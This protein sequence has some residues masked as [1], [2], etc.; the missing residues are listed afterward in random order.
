MSVPVPRK[1]LSLND[2]IDVLNEPLIKAH[3]DID[4]AW[5]YVHQF[6]DQLEFILGELDKCLDRDYFLENYYCIRDENGRI[7]TLYPYWDHQW[8]LAEAIDEEYATK[9]K[10]LIIV[11]KPRQCGATEWT[12]AANFH[13]TIFT[14]NAFTLSVAQDDETKDQIFKKMNNAY[15]LLPWWMRPKVMF[16]KE[17][18]YLEFQEPDEERRITNP[19]LGSAML[20]QHAQKM[21]GV[22]IGKTIRNF[23]G[24]E[25]SR[26][27]DASVF[28]SDIR[29]S[30]NAD[31]QFGIL[32]STALGRSGFYYNHWKGAV[33]GKNKWRPL[34][35]PVYKVRKYAR[36]GE[37]ILK[38]Q[39][40]FQLDAKEQQFTERVKKEEKFDIPQ[41]FWAWRRSEIE[42]VVSSTGAPWDHFESYPIT[43]DEAFQSSGICAFDRLSLQYQ[44]LKGVCKP[45]WVGEIS[46]VNIE[47]GT[48]DTSMIRAVGD[49]ETLMPRKSENNQ[50]KTD[51]LYIW[52]MPDDTAFYQISSDTALGVPDGDYSV[53]QVIRL[54]EGAEPDTQVAEWWGHC[55]PTEFAKINAALGLWYHGINSAAEIATEY[56]GPGISCGDKLKD[57]DYPNLYRMV[58][59]DRVTNMYTNW[60]HWVTNQKT[61]DLI[62]ATTNEALLAHTCIIRSEE[63][64]DEMYDFGSDGGL[65]F[66]GQG[67]FDDGVMSWQIGLYCLREATR[68]MKQNA[69][70]KDDRST[71]DSK[72]HVFGVYDNLG[73]QR[74]QYTEKLI[75]EQMIQGKTNWTVKPIMICKAN[76]AF[77]P[78]FHGTGAQNELHRKYGMRSVDILPDVVSAYSAAIETGRGSLDD[79]D[80]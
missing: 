70:P 23:H 80:W 22:A 54:G 41:S 75:A 5:E 62:I 10:C 67:N 19:G 33:A 36:Q 2:A 25:V 13:R 15:H 52:E 30:M 78:I 79:D 76:T 24:S 6:P 53:C 27:P 31:D 55:P 16:R 50:L 4:L 46:L 20:I 61:R 58:H 65:R 63:L 64:I 29:P 60:W 44:R 9:G 34:F 3:N 40:D 45:L 11:L 28:T 47:A 74:G 68:D 56:Q 69:E 73:R 48:V 39:P 72:L 71:A 59:K 37:K 26:W 8:I 18:N 35:I 51:R 7:R 32:E 1:D 14:P 42:E 21:T 77:S 57:L 12:S 66:E 49:D 38:S 43:P 17:G